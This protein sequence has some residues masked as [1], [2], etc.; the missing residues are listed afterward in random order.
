[1]KRKPDLNKE[2]SEQSANHPHLTPEEQ[3]NPQVLLDRFFKW[4]SLDEAKEISWKW[5]KAALTGNADTFMTGEDRSRLIHFYESTLGLTEATHLIRNRSKNKGK[6]K[7][8]L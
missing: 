8:S 6:G 7:R 1:M 2:R 4:Y 3:H 5:L